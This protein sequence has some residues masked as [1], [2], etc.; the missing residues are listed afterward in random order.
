ML[1]LLFTGQVGHWRIRSEKIGE[2][3]SFIID[4]RKYSSLNNIVEVH[5]IEPLKVSLAMKGS[6][7]TADCVCAQVNLTRSTQ[8]PLRL[9]LPCERN[10]HEKESIYSDF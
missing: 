3:F 5:L 9:E 2:E 6:F 1:I 10:P 4:D 8:R 7:L